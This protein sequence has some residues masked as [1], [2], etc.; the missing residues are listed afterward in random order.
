MDLNAVSVL[1]IVIR[2]ENRLVQGPIFKNW[3]C[4]IKERYM[5]LPKKIYPRFTIRGEI[6]RV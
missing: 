1:V 5:S 4:S 3:G 2:D 6:A